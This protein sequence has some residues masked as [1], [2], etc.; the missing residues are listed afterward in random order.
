[1]HNN[2]LRVYDDVTGAIGCT[3]LIK[4]NKIATDHGIKCQVFAK[5]DFFS[6]GGS[7]KDRIGLSMILEAEKRGTIKPGDTIVEATSGNTGIGLVLT[8]L[9]RG[10]KSILTIPDKMSDEKINILR[11]LGAKVIITPTD[12][13][14]AHPDSYV[15]LA[16]RIGQ[17][18]GHFYINQYNNQDNQLAH[19]KTTSVE[20][21][22][23][24]QGKL[25]YMFICTGTCGTIT[26][27]GRGLHKHD[28]SIKIVG[29][30]PVGSV[31]ARPVEMNPP[32]KSYKMEGIGQSRVPGNMD[33]TEVFEF[34]KV[35]DL[36]SFQMAR[37]IIEKQGLL[38]GG[39]CG[40]VLLGTFN[41]LKEKGLDQDENLRCVVFMPDGVRNYMSKLINDNWMVGNGFYPIERL[42]EE[43]HPLADKTISDLKNLL[44]LP[45]YDARLTVNDC[46]DLF[47]KGHSMVPI[48]ANGII[49]GVV[50]KNSLVRCVVEKKLHGMSS[51]AHCTQREYL[52][53]PQETP[54][55]VISKMLKTEVAVLAVAYGDNGKIRTIYVLTQN[56]I[57]EI[58]HE[59]MKE[60]I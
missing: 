1:M 46:F 51:A 33:Y 31:L 15:S 56:E 2:V 28:P 42:Q 47:K 36:E 19:F 25:D 49:T 43:D 17:E 24:M 10:Y 27:T 29:V 50:T 40:S 20:I 9:A 41:Y 21:W 38:V 30:D 32:P 12:V 52:K 11:A 4:L 45:Y 3:P 60:V 35:D 53:V 26:G 59:S 55:S 34:I 48:R 44:P 57:M 16:I 7:S 58:M 54:L 39:S 13:P 6:A 18:P 8:A 22:E 5:C 14:L 23:Q 37:E